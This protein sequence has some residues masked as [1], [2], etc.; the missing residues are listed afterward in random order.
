MPG[1]CFAYPICCYVYGS[2]SLLMN[3]VSIVIC[4]YNSAR[5]LPE[6]LKYLALQ[7][8]LPSIAWEVIIVDNASSDN[9]AGVAH[10]IWIQLECSVPFRVVQ[11]PTPGLSSAREK[12][13]ETA[14]YDFILFCDDDNWLSSNYVQLAF[15][16]MESNT[17]IGVLGGHGVPYCEIEPPYWFKD[18]ASDYAT[19]QQ[20]EASGDVTFTKS[21]VYGAGAVYRHSALETLRKKGF[22]YFLSDRKGKSLTSGGDVELNHAMTLAGYK[23]WYEEQLVFQHF[24]PKERLTWEYMKRLHRGF[25]FSSSLLL[26]YLYLIRKKRK[27]AYKQNWR[28]F[29][30]MGIWLLIKND[31]LQI[32]S[33]IWK[34]KFK[35]KQ[36][37]L[38]RN[39]SY[40]RGI[41]VNRNLIKQALTQLPQSTWLHENYRGLP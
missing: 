14:H 32:P 34:K 21:Y 19:G 5:R 12:G 26:P 33:S 38:I 1:Y 30:L 2:I 36:I 29:L 40:L 20:S 11:E 10:Q 39:L 31:L 6:T 24:L 25:G 18:F 35:V 13:V 15:Q 23:I 16:I 3:G 22:K 37:E 4:C 9:T 7:K 28:W 27:P 41:Y 8:V 17:E